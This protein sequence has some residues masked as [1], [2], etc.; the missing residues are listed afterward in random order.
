[1]IAALRATRHRA[2]SRL[3]AA[4]AVVPLDTFERLENEADRVACLD[5]PE[6]FDAVGEFFESFPQV[7]DEEVIEA[8]A[9]RGA[10]GAP[11]VDVSHAPRWTT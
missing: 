7:T 6:W 3:I 10:P 4:T 11:N 9:A 1:M 5:T 2:P 8:L